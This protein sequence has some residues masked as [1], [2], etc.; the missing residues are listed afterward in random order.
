MYTNEVEVYLNE[1]KN[2]GLL[3]A[4]REFAL[5]EAISQ[6]DEDAKNEFIEAH[7]RLVVSIAK[8]YV[9]KGMSFLDLIQE[10]NLGLIKAAEKFDRSKGYRFS[11]Y[12]TWWIKQAITRAIDDQSRTIRIPVH[13]REAIRRVSKTGLEMK[14]EL[15]REPSIDELADKLHTSPNKI[16]EILQVSQVSQECFSL[17]SPAGGDDED[18]DNNNRYYYIQDPSSEAMYDQIEFLASL[19][20][21]MRTACGYL[22]HGYRLHELPSLLA[23]HGY[24]NS[25]ISSTMKLI[26]N[27]ELI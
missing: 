10:G 19:H 25:M 14:E 12:A 27:G 13:M 7:L 15:D 21:I 1:I 26:R 16:C 8:K 22:I 2:I 3:S 23:K 17:D 9:E 24:S 4:E 5:A 20:G 11:T 6:G 18:S